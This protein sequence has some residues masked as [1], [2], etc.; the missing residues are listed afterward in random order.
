LE[1]T[2]VDYDLSAWTPWQEF[3]VDTVAPQQAPL[4]SSADYP[5]DTPSGHVHLPGAFTFTSG[6]VDDVMAYAYGF[7][8]LST[9]K[10]AAADGSLTVTLKPRQGWSNCLKVQSIDRAGNYSPQAE[11]CFE[12]K[13]LEHLPAIS[14]GTYPEWGAGGGV[15]IAGEFVFDSGD[16]GDIVTNLRY[17]YGEVSEEVPVGGGASA[18]VNLTPT[19]EGFNEVS[20]QALD[21]DG[22]EVWSY[23]YYFEV[24]AS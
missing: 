16:L 11:Y 22:M 5:Q 3:T 10:P 23:T 19:Q 9:T 21:R 1:S 15:G 6:G 4:V 7:D 14:S 17:S 13:W 2:E 18:K 8:S 20:F 24:N 12:V